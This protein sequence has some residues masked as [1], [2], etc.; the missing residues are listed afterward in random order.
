MLANRKGEQTMKHNA[1]RSSKSPQLPI[2]WREDEYA[3]L[4]SNAADSY[5]DRVS[6][7]I[8]DADDERAEIDI[9]V[10]RMNHDAS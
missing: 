5:D 10:Q 3:A 2:A 4:R 1:Y 9:I 8:F 6:E 7:N